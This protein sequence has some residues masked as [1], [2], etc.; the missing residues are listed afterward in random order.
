MSCDLD[1]NRR[2][3]YSEKENKHIKNVGMARQKVCKQGRDDIKVKVNKYTKPHQ[4]FFQGGGG[5]GHLS[6]LGFGLPP[7][8]YAEN[9]I[10]HVNQ[11]EKF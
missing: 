6:P 5:G 11:L 2:L 1:V 7:L 8:G 10:L 3:H 4:G 9:S